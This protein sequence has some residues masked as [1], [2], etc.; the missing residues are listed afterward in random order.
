MPVMRTMMQSFRC[1][2]DTS[3]SIPTHWMPPDD[4]DLELT[5]ES[6]SE[7][8]SV[9]GGVRLDDD[10]DSDTEPIRGMA[11]TTNNPCGD[12]LGSLECISDMLSCRKAIFEK[13]GQEAMY[14][15]VPQNRWKDLV[16]DSMSAESL[17][18][19]CHLSKIS[20]GSFSQFDFNEQHKFQKSFFTKI[21]AGSEVMQV[22]GD[23]PEK[24]DTDMDAISDEETAPVLSKRSLSPKV[25]S[26]AAQAWKDALQRGQ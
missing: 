4:A 20:A 5:D 10:N 25:L 11:N 1:H 12:I 24:A 18:A 21:D 3:G 26:P 14:C 8:E 23:T 19:D 17:I 13:K 7:A 6:E 15:R 2:K 9:R 16:V 22:P